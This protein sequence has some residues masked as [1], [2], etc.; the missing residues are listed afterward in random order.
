MR[1][2]G[3]WRNSQ[4]DLTANNN[5]NSGLS[6]TSSINLSMTTA[7][8]IKA[9]DLY[10][11]IDINTEERKLEDITK[12]HLNEQLVTFI[13]ELT[14]SVN[15]SKR[16]SAKFGNAILNS[17]PTVADM[18][19]KNEILEERLLM[20]LKSFYEYKPMDLVLCH[21]TLHA[22]EYPTKTKLALT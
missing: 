10:D 16:L 17:A 7:N 2:T 3:L 21:R 8:D 5:D 11:E 19:I 1:I 4:N 22:L 13:N 15:G 18:S 14:Y 6:D 20:L 12:E 9:T